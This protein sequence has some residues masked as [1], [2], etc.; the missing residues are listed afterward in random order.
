MAR[1]NRETVATAALEL[2]DEVGIEGVS[3]RR[4]AQRLGLE[5]PAIY[6]HFRNKAELLSAMAEAAMEPH[7]KARLPTPSE[8]WRAWFAENMR[9]FRRTLLRHRDGARLHAGTRPRQA[10]LGRI[11]H[12]LDFLIASGIPEEHAKMAMLA[13]GYFTVGCVLEEQANSHADS[14]ADKTAG[15]PVLDHEAA[16]EAGLALIIAGLAQT[17]HSREAGD[18]SNL[19][20]P[21]SAS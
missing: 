4:L 11:A 1:Q 9:S 7:A 13:A 16:F 5:Q 17:K 19:D 8:D 21:A 6:W 18:P 3:T 10:D 14:D 2:L 20:D 15:L 12:K